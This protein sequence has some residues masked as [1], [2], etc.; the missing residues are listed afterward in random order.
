MCRFRQARQTLILAIASLAT[1]WTSK[2]A[3]ACMGCMMQKYPAIVLTFSPDSQWLASSNRWRWS[4]GRWT[5]RTTVEIWRVP[6]LKM[7]KQLPEGQKVIALA[8]SPDSKILAASGM[9]NWVSL[10][11]LPEGKRVRRFAVKTQ[12]YSGVRSLAFSP[13]GRFLATGTLDGTIHLWQMP[14]GKLVATFIA[15]LPVASLAFSPDGKKLAAL[16]EGGR[17]QLWDIRAKK[18]LWEREDKSAYFS[19]AFTKDGRRLV[20]AGYS[21]LVLST[22]DGSVINGQDPSP[23]YSPPGGVSDDGQFIAL[24]DYLGSFKVKRSHDFKDI[25]RAS[26]IGWKLKKRLHHWAEKI[27]QRTSLPATKLFPRPNLPFAFGA[28][29]SRDNRWLAFGFDNGQIK[30]WRI[31]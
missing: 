15:D 5:T 11:K 17:V 3:Q 8:F 6:K 29:F 9:N 12:G 21:L 18:L 14:Q 24:C 30:L 7:V 4:G 1:L 10:W 25:W 19:I 16:V 31:R 20:G 27:E 26:I 23:F 22:V 2:F 28:A 13:N